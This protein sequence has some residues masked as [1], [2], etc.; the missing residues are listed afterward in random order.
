[1]WGSDNR[2]PMGVEENLDFYGILC[3]GELRG[4]WAIKNWRNKG[5]MWF[6]DDIFSRRW[7][8]FRSTDWFRFPMKNSGLKKPQIQFTA[9]SNHSQETQFALEVLRLH[10]K[11]ESLALYRGWIIKKTSRNGLSGLGNGKPYPIWIDFFHGITRMRHFPT[12]TGLPFVFFAVRCLFYVALSLGMSTVLFPQRW[13]V[14]KWV[15]CC[16]MRRNYVLVFSSKPRSG[17][18][19]V[20]YYVCR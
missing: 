15:K 17:G 11:E 7:E 6:C 4:E 10:F 12:I 1:M 9:K 8:T 18:S 16:I 19:F 3:A 2:R 13:I 5:G 20:E 14:V